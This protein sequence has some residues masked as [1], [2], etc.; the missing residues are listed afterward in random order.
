ML[1]NALLGGLTA[2]LI[3]ALAFVQFVGSNDAL[4]E[5]F[6]DVDPDVVYRIHKEMIKDA[7]AGKLADVKNDEAYDEIF[8]MKL[9]WLQV[10]ETLQAK[11]VKA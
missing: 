9:A 10:H 7:L 8:R 1:K 11:L 5:R 4:V 3:A 2:A 6:P